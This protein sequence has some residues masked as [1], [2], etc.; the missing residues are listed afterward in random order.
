MTRTTQMKLRRSSDLAPGDTA[1]AGAMAK[2]GAVA[3]FNRGL[4]A[5]LAKRGMKQHPFRRRAAK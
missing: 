1:E 4:D 5:Y 2:K 3:E